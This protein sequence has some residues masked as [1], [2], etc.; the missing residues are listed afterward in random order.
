MPWKYWSHCV[1][2]NAPLLIFGFYYGKGNNYSTAFLIILV[3][4]S[5]N[6][7]GGIRS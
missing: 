5:H 4:L 3:E 6:D 2:A 7:F 1:N